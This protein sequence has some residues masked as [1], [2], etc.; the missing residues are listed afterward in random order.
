VD[1]YHAD[2]HGSDTSSAEEFMEDLK[3]SVIIIS[4]GNHGGHQHPCQSIL[5]RY[6]S[7]DPKPVVFQTNKYLKGGKGG[8]VADEFIA[9]LEADDEDGTILVSVDKAVGNYTVSYRDLSRTYSIKDRGDQPS[10]VVIESLLPNPDG[11]DRINEEVMLR[12]D[13]AIVVS[14][15]GW[16][17]EDESGRIWALVGLGNIDS[18]Q[19]AT[20]RRNGMPMSL[21]NNEDEISLFNA[22]HIL[23]DRFTYIGSQR[24]VWIQTGH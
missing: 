7:L 18:G 21:N 10:A 24:A 5:N 17:L 2:H 14:M 20:I 3:P 23:V 16:T 11:S 22:N 1:V 19:S 6:D 4:N 9:D 15:T 8:N 13:S 12:N